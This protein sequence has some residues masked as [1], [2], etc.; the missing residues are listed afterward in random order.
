MHNTEGNIP[1][2]GVIKNWSIFLC[3]RGCLYPVTQRSRFFGGILCDFSSK[4]P[5]RP[6]LL[7]S[8]PS[9]AAHGQFLQIAPGHNVMLCSDHDVIMKNVH[10]GIPQNSKLSI[11]SGGAILLERNEASLINVGVIRAWCVYVCVCVWWGGGSERE[12]TSA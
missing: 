3:R 10:F 5:N 8:L 6:L 12:A 11:M 2:G 4:S 7:P 9:H 1:Q